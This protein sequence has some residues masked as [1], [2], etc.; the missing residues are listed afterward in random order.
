MFIPILRKG[1]HQLMMT[2][3]FSAKTTMVM[4]CRSYMVFGSAKDPS[5]SFGQLL[6]FVADVDEMGCDQ[7]PGFR[8]EYLKGFDRRIMRESARDK[9]T[10]T[11]KVH[12]ILEFIKLKRTY[13]YR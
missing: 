4:P 9:R 11:R 2:T 5:N 7:Y 3:A 13:K 10:T 12:S 1:S 6:D 8:R